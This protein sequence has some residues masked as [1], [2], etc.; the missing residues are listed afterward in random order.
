MAVLVWL[1][2]GQLLSAVVAFGLTQ[3]QGEQAIPVP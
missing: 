1:P 2:A 3:K